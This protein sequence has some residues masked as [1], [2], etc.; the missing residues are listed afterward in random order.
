MPGRQVRSHVRATATARYSTG[1]VAHLKSEEP[2]N[3]VVVPLL[4]LPNNFA[5]RWSLA[6]AGQ[7]GRRLDL[8]SREDV[9]AMN[10]MLLIVI[11]MRA[12]V[13][14]DVA[15]PTNSGPCLPS[16]ATIVA[17]RNS[18]EPARDIRRLLER[19]VAQLFTHGI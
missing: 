2:I 6:L 4:D 8:S 5:Q 10:V 7:K 19:A 12:V 1:D 14:E 18:H 16:G 3:V 15:G 17:S 9:E 13:T 11:G